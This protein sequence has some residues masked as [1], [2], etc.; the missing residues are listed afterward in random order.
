MRTVIVIEGSIAGLNGKDGLMREHFRKGMKKKE[1]FQFLIRSQT[2]N[3]HAGKV[4]ITYVGYKS[5]LMDWDNF[6]ASF[7]YLGDSLVKTK[8]IIDDNP[9]IVSQFIIKQVK[10]K[11]VDQRIEI[12]IEDL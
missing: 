11:R 4:S 5:V 1:K 7:K 3:R 8:V 2:R 6:A 9:S 10:C 12:I